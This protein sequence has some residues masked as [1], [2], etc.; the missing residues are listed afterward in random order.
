MSLTELEVVRDQRVEVEKMQTQVGER[1][2]EEN[3]K[4]AI[5]TDRAAAQDHRLQAHLYVND[6]S[7][8][9]TTTPTSY[10]LAS[11]GSAP[12]QSHNHIGSTTDAVPPVLAPPLWLLH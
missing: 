5:L 1:I 10:S 9:H 2:E 7:A 11:L 6:F 12:Q 3:L 4:Q 8:P